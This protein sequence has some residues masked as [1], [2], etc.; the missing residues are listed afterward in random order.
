LNL[1]ATTLEVI[2]CIGDLAA[3]SVLADRIEIVPVFTR[4]PAAVD[5]DF[6][7][8]TLIGAKGLSLCGGQKDQ[9]NQNKRHHTN[10]SNRAFQQFSESNSCTLAKVLDN[11]AAV[12]VI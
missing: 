5:R 7:A 2:E 1:A 3:G 10:H 12:K 6:F 11:F 8:V 9:P 4:E